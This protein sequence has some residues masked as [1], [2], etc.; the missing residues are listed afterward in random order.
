MTENT[1]TP[2]ISER[3]KDYLRRFEKKNTLPAH[4]LAFGSPIQVYDWW[5]TAMCK[6]AEE[7]TTIAIQ[8]AVEKARKEEQIKCG[9][10]KEKI[11]GE[12]V[13]HEY[14]S[15]QQAKAEGKKE[16][17][18]EVFEL[19][20]KKVLPKYWNILRTPEGIMEISLDNY[21][22][23]RKQLEKEETG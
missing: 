21:N 16:G 17:R 12:A 6:F 19:F 18:G 14:N 7:E 20:E 1:P 11:I 22:E 5:V 8:K 2:T 15:I 13:D 9:V 23:A 4:G 10:E 3:A